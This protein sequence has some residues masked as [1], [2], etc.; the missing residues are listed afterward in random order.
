MKKILYMAAVLAVLAGCSKT[1]YNT[2]EGGERNIS[3]SVAVDG[4]TTRALYDGAGRIKFEKYDKFA[5]AIAKA[6]DPGTA[7]KV[8]TKSGYAASVY[9]SDFTIADETAESPV[10]NGNI[11]SVVDADWADE[12]LFYGVFPSSVVYS[13]E[14]NLSKWAISLPQKQASTQSQWDKKYTAM[15]MQPATISTSDNTHNDQWGEYSATVNGNAVKFAHIF[16]YGRI[17]FAGIPEKYADCKV[18]SV[19]IKAVGGNKMLAG[20]VTLDITKSIDEVELAPYSNSS[21]YDSI[22]LT[23]EEAVSVSD[24]AA[25]FVALPGDY[26]VE[27]TVS[28]AKAD[29]IFERPGLHIRRSEI[30]SPTVNFKETDQVVSHDVI[31]AEGESWSEEKYMSGNSQNCI[32]STYPVRSWGPEGKKMNFHLYYPDQINNN[33]GSNLGEWG[34]PY[35]QQMAY[36][37]LT[38]GQAVLASEASFYGIKMLK[39]NLGI[40][41]AGVT[42][43]FTVRLVD[44]AQTTV[45]GSVDVTGDGSN[46]DGQNYF[47]E[48]PTSAS[49]CLEICASD[50][51]DSNCRPFVGAMYLN[52][53]PEIVISTGDIKTSYAAADFDIPYAVYSSELEPTVS[54]SDSWITATLENGLLKV[55]VAENAGTKRKGTVTMSLATDPVTETSFAV[56]QTSP[57]SQECVLSLT[58]QDIY[59]AAKLEEP[60]IGTADAKATSS[61][62]HTFKAK[63]VNDSSFEYDVE[64]EFTA[65]NWQ[66]SGLTADHEMAIVV[67]KGDIK[68]TEP[69]GVVTRVVVDANK[70][71]RNSNYYELSVV[72]SADGVTYETPGTSDCSHTGS[73]PHFISTVNNTNENRNYFNIKTP[74]GPTLTLYSFEIYFVS[75]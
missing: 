67:G 69:V 41:T 26:D 75:E 60:K 17:D 25:W 58:A 23:P 4:E 71:H 51:S 57:N 65:F 31:L 55:S 59:D 11:Y 10:F 8:A 12:F 43:K 66:E 13:A 9:K 19:T 36:Q 29:L 3:L 28:T 24:Y 44:G 39:V 56:T 68:C 1:E 73:E 18:K 15:L 16:G 62:K 34:G 35:K 70:Y 32:T 14:Q 22:M 49:G 50:F 54:T 74:W 5:G 72:F 6:D 46:Y 20:N 21:T 64:L 63:G 47:F 30:A 27:I 2:V 61:F 53:D 7:I 42:G 37:N 40:Y 38:G 48:N 33:Y 52:P 45:L